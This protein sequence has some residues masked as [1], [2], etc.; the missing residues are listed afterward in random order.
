[1][2]VNRATVGV[3]LGL[4]LMVGDG[5]RG[6]IGRPW[7]NINRRRRRQ[8]RPV[9]HWEEWPVE[10]IEAEAHNDARLCR[11]SAEHDRQRRDSG[12]CDGNQ[13]CPSGHR[14]LPITKTRTRDKRTPQPSPGA[15]RLA[16][17]TVGPRAEQA[18]SGSLCYATSGGG[19]PVSAIGLFG[20]LL[21]DCTVDIPRYNG[22]PFEVGETGLFR[23]QF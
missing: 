10:G 2:A 20:Q 13:F 19:V 1:M 8:L 3:G 22:R 21:V 18:A 6:V 17:F 5:R 4:D 12:E 23:C 15:R 16:P 7:H 14:Y 9:E 11:R